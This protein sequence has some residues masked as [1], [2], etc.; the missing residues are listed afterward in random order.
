RAA[1]V[2]GLLV[3]LIEAAT[4]RVEEPAVIRAAEAVLLGDAEH[5]AS[6]A[7]GAAVADET[8]LPLAVAIEH[9]ILAEQTNGTGPVFLEL[10][11]RGDGVPVAPEQGAHGR[12]GPYSRHALIL[13]LGQHRSP[14]VARIKWLAN[15]LIFA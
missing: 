5:H 9:E 15:L 2:L 4:R 6:A 13:L 3:W 1:R 10:C 14:P 12:S 11:A 7:V 8:E